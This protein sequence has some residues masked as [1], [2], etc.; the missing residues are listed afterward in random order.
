MLLLTLAIGVIFSAALYG[1]AHYVWAVP[2][3]HRAEGPKPPPRTHAQA[4]GP[5]REA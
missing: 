5:G 4:R 2:E 3:R 1:A